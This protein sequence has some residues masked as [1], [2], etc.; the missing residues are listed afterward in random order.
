MNQNNQSTYDHFAVNQGILSNYQNA[1]IPD[2]HS[3]IKISQLTKRYDNFTALHNINLSLPKGKV[4]GLLGPNGSGKT[5]LIKLLANLLTQYEGSIL[6]DGKK[7]GF[8][9]KSIVSY[10][11][12]RNYLIDKWTTNNAITYF[13]D[14]YADFD[15][16]K[17]QNLMAQ[18]GIDCTRRFK[19]LSKGTKEKVQL[20]LVLSRN[21]KLYIFDE[22]IAGVD[23]A[24]RDFIFSMILKNYNKDASVIIS[25]HLILEAESIFD[26]AIFLKNG[27]IALAGSSNDI[28]VKHQKSLNDLF[29]EVFRYD[30]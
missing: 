25:T 26:Y 12:D 28:R 8:D 13:E 17:A 21:A 24:T 3:L 10:L 22:P 29:R 18:L 9:T 14:F 20:A 4:I 16:A 30:A 15:K 1:T 6:I 7:P 23:P 11:P 2:E 5:T 27:Q 19:I